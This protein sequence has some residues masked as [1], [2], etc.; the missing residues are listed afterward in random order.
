MEF[1]GF[2]FLIIVFV[3]VIGYLVQDAFNMYLESKEEEEEA[4]VEYTYSPTR[5]PIYTL[6]DWCE[7]KAQ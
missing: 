1:L 6:T 2:L 4:Y 3:A 7:Q 5:C